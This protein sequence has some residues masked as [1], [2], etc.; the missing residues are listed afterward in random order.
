MLIIQHRHHDHNFCKT[1]VVCF[2]EREMDTSMS[3][4]Y[5]NHNA[6]LYY[7]YTVYRACTSLAYVEHTY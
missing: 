6:Y 5:K 7:L 1:V 3:V 4:S 2:L